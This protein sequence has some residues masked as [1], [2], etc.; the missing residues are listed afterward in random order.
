MIATL[1]IVG[2]AAVVASS[3]TGAALAQTP[4]TVQS[5]LDQEFQIVGTIPS[6]AGPGLF[7]QKKDRL[8]FCVVAET[9]TSPDVATRYCKPVR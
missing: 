1:R 4:V 2:V 9:V 5:L 8:F 7:L 6:Q 3:A